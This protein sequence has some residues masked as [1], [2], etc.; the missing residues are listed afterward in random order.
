MKT[1]LELIELN[2][3]ECIA[4]I[5]KFLNDTIERNNKSI[6]WLN[7]I[8]RKKIFNITKNLIKY[9]IKTLILFCNLS[10]D[11][12]L[13]FILLVVLVLSIPIILGS[14]CYFVAV[15]TMIL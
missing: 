8:A 10:Y 5:I 1:V 11:L 14:I 13:F 7:N 2:I 15:I 6:T 9:L 3:T 4:D 12:L